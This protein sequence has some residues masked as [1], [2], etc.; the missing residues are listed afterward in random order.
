MLG[1]N[2][3]QPADHNIISSFDQ[4][5][6]ARFEM[7]SFKKNL[8]GLIEIFDKITQSLA[9]QELQ[10][11]ELKLKDVKSGFSLIENILEG[12]ALGLTK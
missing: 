1:P 12:L 11:Y 6:E 7:Q 9:E 10:D 8:F 2:Y 5:E 3:Q 4:I